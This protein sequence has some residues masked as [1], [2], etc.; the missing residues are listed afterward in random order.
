MSL[1]HNRR[2]DDLSMS[3]LL[4][5]IDISVMTNIKRRL[6][7]RHYYCSCSEPLVYISEGNDHTPPYP[8]TWRFFNLKL[9]R[10]VTGRPFEVLSPLDETS[11]YGSLILKQLNL[12]FTPIEQPMPSPC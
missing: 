12:D 6:L 7:K 10:Y 3:K 2:H 9:S 5:S 1:I 8:H 4:H 11:T